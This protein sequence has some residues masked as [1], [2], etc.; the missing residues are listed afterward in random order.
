MSGNLSVTYEDFERRCEFHGAVAASAKTRRQARM[1]SRH[2]RAS[3]ALRGGAA[4]RPRN[5]RVI[6]FGESAQSARRHCRRARCKTAVTPRDLHGTATIGR[7]NGAAPEALPASTERATGTTSP[8][9]QSSPLPAGS[10][11]RKRDLT[12]SCSGRRSGAGQSPRSLPTVWMRRT[13]E[14]S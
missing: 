7:R 5:G 11:S 9:R 1:R 6:F 8:R 10:A 14:A 13:R 12:R 4:A 3:S 2:F